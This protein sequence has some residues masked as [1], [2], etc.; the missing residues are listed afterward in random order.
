ML[1]RNGDITSPD[2]I[3][4]ESELHVGDKFLMEYDWCKRIPCMNGYKPDWYKDIAEFTVVDIVCNMLV[5]P[6]SIRVR[7]HCED[8]I[9]KKRCGSKDFDVPEEKVLERIETAKNKAA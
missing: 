2:E 5:N 1:K 7:L 6:S 4:V 8:E 3:E 9:F